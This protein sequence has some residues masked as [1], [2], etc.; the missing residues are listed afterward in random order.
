MIKSKAQIVQAQQ[1]N[2]IEAM[3]KIINKAITHLVNN[4]SFANKNFR[5]RY[6]M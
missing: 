6:L 4:S 1:H 2:K 5:F 3:H